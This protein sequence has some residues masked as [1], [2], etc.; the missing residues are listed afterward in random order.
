MK[1]R[2]HIAWK[3]HSKR[4]KAAEQDTCSQPLSHNLFLTCSF[5]HALAHNLLLTTSFSHALSHMLFL[6]CA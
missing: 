4:A 1:Q 2:V 5:S 3:G 6:A